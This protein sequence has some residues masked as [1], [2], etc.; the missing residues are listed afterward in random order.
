M[1]Q[2]ADER[3]HEPQPGAGW[4]EAWDFTFVSAGM[5]LAGYVRLAVVPQ[6]RAAWCWAA[7][8]GLEQPLVAVRLHELVI[9]RGWPLEVRGDGLWCGLFCE[10]ALSHWTV[11][12]EAFALRFDDPLDAWRDE[13]GELLPLGFDLEWEDDGRGSEATATYTRTCTVHGEVLVGGDAFDVVASGSR[14]HG[15]RPVAWEESCG[16]VTARPVLISPVLVPPHRVLRGVVADGA[17]TG[18]AEWRG[19]AATAVAAAVAGT[20]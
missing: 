20:A 15:W 19:S 1:V 11:G 7:V 10:T 2:P 18:W 16:D 8:V 12:L 14:S 4:Q 3:F 13:R 9:P 17:E 6:E 5:S